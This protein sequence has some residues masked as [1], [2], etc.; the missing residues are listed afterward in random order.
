MFCRLIFLISFVQ[1]NVFFFKIHK[2][3]NRI[4]T[5]RQ[6]NNKKNAMNKQNNQKVY[7][8]LDIMWD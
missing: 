2:M 8:F 1:I 7:L 5:N 6:K 3:R 4:I